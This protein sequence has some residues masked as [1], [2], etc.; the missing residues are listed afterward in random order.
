MTPPREPF[1]DRRTTSSPTTTGRRR[2][3]HAVAPES[4]E[5]PLRLTSLG[6]RI[7]ALLAAD[8]QGALRDRADAD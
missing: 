2:A 8:A 7:A 1:A 5:R 6:E 3:L 4:N